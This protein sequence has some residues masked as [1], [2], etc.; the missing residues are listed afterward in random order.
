[1]KPVDFREL[2]LRINVSLKR[3]NAIY[4][5][6]RKLKIANLELDIDTKTVI[7]SGEKIDLTSKEFALLETLLENK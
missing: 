3:S 5:P 6:G 2:L 7:R 4:F 1:V